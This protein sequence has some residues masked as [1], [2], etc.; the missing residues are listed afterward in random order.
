MIK[1]GA[2]LKAQGKTPGFQYAGGFLLSL[3]LRLEP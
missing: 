1:A 2:G 3:S